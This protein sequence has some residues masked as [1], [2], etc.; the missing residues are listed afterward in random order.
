MLGPVTVAVVMARTKRDVAMFGGFL[1]FTALATF[2]W[3]ILP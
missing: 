3:N 2:I 1:L